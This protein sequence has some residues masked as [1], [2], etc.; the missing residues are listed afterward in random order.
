MGKRG[1]TY[2]KQ[3]VVL[4]NI[5][6]GPKKNNTENMSNI[7]NK[8]NTCIS[9]KCKSQWTVIGQIHFRYLSAVISRNNYYLISLHIVIVYMP[10]ISL[11]YVSF[12]LVSGLFFLGHPIAESISCKSELIYL[13]VLKIQCT[14]SL[15]FNKCFTQIFLEDQT[16]FTADCFGH[17]SG[18]RVYTLP[19]PTLDRYQWRVGGGIF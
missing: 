6:G 10:K 2:L 5:Q 17:T 11:V 18:I 1:C 19:R 3:Y 7:H 4:S 12:W 14:R 13:C 8:L 9:S 16:S 15:L